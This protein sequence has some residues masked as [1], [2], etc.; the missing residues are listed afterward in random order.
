MA[1]SAQFTEQVAYWKAQLSG[2]PPTLD[3]P[4]DYARSTDQ[5]MTS[6]TLALELSVSLSQALRRFSQGEG[7]TAFMT[8]LATFK[9]LLRAYTGQ[10]DILV[11]TPIAGRN[12][13]ELEELL[14]FFVGTLVLRT[15]LSADSQ[16]NGYP[17]FR[18]L[19]QRV[20]QVALDAYTHQ[21]LPFE[22]LV[23]VLQQPERDLSR[24]PI[25]QV[26]FNMLNLENEPIHLSGLTVE[27]LSLVEPKANFDVTLYVDDDESIKLRLLYNATRFAKERM[28]ELLE[29]Y[30]CLL[31]QAMRSPDTLLSDF[32]LV[33]AQAKAFLPDPTLALHHDAQETLHYRFSC[34]AADIPNRPAVVGQDDVLTYGQLERLSNQLAHYLLAQGAKGEVVAIYAARSPML[35]CALLGVLKAGAAFVMLDSA[36]PAARLAAYCRQAKPAVLIQLAEAGALPEAL[37]PTTCFV[38]PQAPACASQ[39][40]TPYASCA[41]AL[42]VTADDLA[43]IAFTSG[44]TG[45]PKGIL[46]T[47]APV[48]HFIAWHRRTFGLTEKDRFSLLSGLAHDPLLRDIFTP[49]TL[50]ATLYVPDALTMASGRLARWLGEHQITACHLTPPMGQLL[51]QDDTRLDK[52]RYLF[53]GGDKLPA[54]LVKTM[55]ALAPH[56]QVVNFYGATE[57]PQA[58]SYFMAADQASPRDYVP[59][60]RG[61]DAVQLLVLNQAGELAGISEVGEIVVRTPYL[62]QGYLGAAGCERFRDLFGVPS[63]KTGDWGRYLPTGDVELLGRADAQIKIRG[64]RIEPS[65]IEAAL[66]TNAATRQAV[67][68]VH[69]TATGEHLVAYLVPVSAEEPASQVRAQ[70]RALLPDYMAPS[71]FV[72]L[73]ALPLTPNGKV[74]F[75]ALPAPERFVTT[76]DYRAPQTPT[77]ELLAAIWA[78]VLKVPQERVISIHDNFFALG[79]HSLLAVQVLSRLQRAFKVELPLRRL[80]E[81]PTIA[82]L[83]QAIENSKEAF[84]PAIEVAP[85]RNDLPLSF[86]QRRLWF[87][88]QLE[89]PG[90]TYNIFLSRRIRGPLNL[91]YLERSLSELVRRHESLRTTFCLVDGQPK[92]VIHPARNIALP[93]VELAELT[94]AEQEARVRRLSRTEAEQPFDLEQGP[95]VRMRLLKLGPQEHILLIAMH[96]IISDAWSSGILM[97]E[98]RAL[99]EAYAQNKP[100]PLPELPIQYADF[101]YWQQQQ[102]REQLSQQLTFWKEHLAGELPVL[103]L[104][105]DYARPSQQTLCSRALS[106]KLSE[107]LSKELPQL[108]RR[109]GATLFMTLVAAFKLLLYRHTGQEDVI[110]G[111]PSAARNRA[112]VEGLIGFFI[113]TLVL[114][115]DLSQTPTFAELVGR[116][117]QVALDAYAHQDVPFEKLVEE[118]L[119]ARNL[120]HTPIFQ[121]WVNL[122]TPTDFSNQPMA[123]LTI[124]RTDL[125]ERQAKFDLSLYI[126]V[127]SPIGFELVYNADLFSAARMEQLLAQYHYLLQQVVQQPDTRISDY[128]LV[129]P[130]VKALL[131]DPTLAL[132]HDAQE[133]LHHRFSCVAADIPNRPAVVGQDDVLTYGQLERL[134]NQ[135]AHYLLA[136]GARGGGRHLRRAQPDAGLRS[137]GAQS[138]RGLRDARFG[139]PGCPFGGT[140]GK[141]SPPFSFSWQKPAHCRK[142]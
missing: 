102:L 122:L 88:E 91:A 135:L 68:R 97:R 114:R 78:E 124:E 75:A 56:A 82:Q 55:N 11:G 35:V 40:L 96:H 49:L 133:T 116:V 103:D 80:F 79:G 47:Q 104:P 126:S 138:G 99:Y 142:R 14:G 128:S 53:F 130:P 110:V 64:F 10:E 90:A 117:R 54:A 127:G 66:M 129:P 50:G 140:A 69:P 42:C 20:R 17:T 34:L 95:L 134:S 131:P 100:S 5:P 65:E 81:S 59:I 24:S 109:L 45:Q 16:S 108:S 13:A 22:K 44:S 26:W 107:E 93:V 73:P 27:T 121:V 83:S 89:G 48:A 8:L 136:Q 105:R 98:L 21:D 9:L 57:T 141:P 52:L 29:Q 112:E 113:N 87:L 60:G 19:V 6:G 38:L 118:L 94:Q 33:T 86:A 36:Y 25:F 72:W 67:V 3:L 46:G 4:H 58:M 63:Y 23:E 31:Q 70:V 123:G 74:D 28:A 106:I 12:Q 37:T 30:N 125:G 39:L 101:A 7:V 115:S 111:T 32:S 139:V 76:A 1:E 92:Q 2:A 61:I 132:Q 137:W 85:H 15:D 120:S 62:T 77:Q 84:L 51:T 43:Y 119:P 71:A 18:Q 41:P